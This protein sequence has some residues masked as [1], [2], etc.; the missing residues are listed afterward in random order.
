MRLLVL[1][2]ALLPAEVTVSPPVPD[3]TDLSS[4]PSEYHDI[5]EV[6]RKE[7]AFS[8]PPHRPCSCAFDLLPRATLLTSP[9]Y[10]LSHPEREIVCACFFFISNKNSSL[11]PCINYRGLDNIT[12]KNKYPLPLINSTVFFKLNL[13]NAYHLAWI[14]KGPL[15]HSEYLVM[16]FGLTNVP[17]IFQML[18]NDFLRDFLNRFIFV[19]LDDILP[20]PPRT[21]PPSSASETCGEQVIRESREM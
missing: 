19:C 21:H 9:L 18:L 16:P 4:V 8:L 20:E 13:G 14:Q 3:S 5:G 10:N 11:L 2:S 17:A 12:V 15:G 1:A 6:L 7:K